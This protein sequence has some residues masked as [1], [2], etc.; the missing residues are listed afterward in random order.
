MQ[1]RL[2]KEEI[3]KGKRLIGTWIQIG[4]PEVVEMV[5]LA[6]FDFAVIDTEHSYFGIETSEN[7]VRAADAVDLIPFIRVSRKDPSLVMKALDTG[8][9]G[10]VYPGVLC[11]QDAEEAVSA[12]KY[13]PLGNRGACP[14]VRAAGHVARDWEKHAEHSNE[15]LVSVILVEGQEGV[16]NFEEIIGVPHIDVIM[17]GPFDLSVSLGVGGQVEHPLV[18]EKFGEMID[19]AASRGVA[20]MP[21]IFNPDL[22]KVAELSDHWFGR[23]CQ[24]LIVNT[25]KLMFS[26]GM[27]QNLETAWRSRDKY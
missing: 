8:A 19:L 23:G 24:S 11:R 12:S 26:W 5:G 9:A 18:M 6:G 13:P 15:D 22:K 2:F 25:D 3:R 4:S 1:K 20:L 16:E 14:F 17:M 27:E 7:L 10:F 21:N